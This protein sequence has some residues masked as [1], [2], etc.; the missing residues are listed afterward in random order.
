MR[1]YEQLAGKQYAYLFGV[2]RKAQFSLRRVSNFFHITKGQKHVRATGL[3]VIA[4]TK[5]LSLLEI[6]C[7][8]ISVG[9]TPVKQ[10]RTSIGTQLTVS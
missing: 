3:G 8:D 4:Q 1:E 6:L 10:Q 7:G 2:Q 5:W 9:S